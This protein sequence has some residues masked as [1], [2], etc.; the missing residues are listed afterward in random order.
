MSELIRAL[1][2]LAEPPQA[3]HGA[4]AAAMGIPCPTAAEHA[5]VFLFQLFPYASVQLGPEGKL[6]GVARDRVAGFFRALGQTPP[7]EPDH[8]AVLLG[9]YAS[10]VERADEAHDDTGRAAWARARQALLVEHILSWLPAFGRRVADIGGPAY[11]GWA[12]LLDELLAAE[13]ARTPAAA[14]QLPRHL[15]EAA[16]LPDP[17]QGPVDDFLE[18]LL[19]PGRTGLILTASDLARA[20]DDLG[21]GRRVAERRFVIRALLDQDPEGFLGWL[22]AAAAKASSDWDSHWLVRTPTGAWWRDR[23][24]TTSDLLAQLAADARSIERVV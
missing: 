5:D 9:A 14:T 8:L 20:A 17:R 18:G 2:A 21:L 16:L 24:A 1:G 7:T 10:L 19:A 11:R 3:Q 6:G 4:L 15:A 23:S 12:G 22:G 13:A